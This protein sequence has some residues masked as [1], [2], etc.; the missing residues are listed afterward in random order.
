MTEMWETMK[1]LW[2]NDGEIR[3]PTYSDFSGILNAI[4]LDEE[5]TYPASGHW[6][7]HVSQPF[8][9]S[10]A[11]ICMGLGSRT[12]CSCPNSS[13]DIKEWWKTCYWGGIEQVV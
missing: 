6:P 11:S 1:G 4:E 5:R 8:W 9:P 3:G 13:V 10:A 2:E 12:Q 7:S